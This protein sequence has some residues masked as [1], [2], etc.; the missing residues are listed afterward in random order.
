MKT[1]VVGGNG[2]IGSHLVDKLVENDWEVVILDLH[3]RRYDAIP[4]QVRFIRGDL[5]Q[6]YLVR[7]SLMGVDVVFHLAWSGIPEISIIDP[8]AAIQTNLHPSI[9]LFDACL[10]AKVGRVIFISSGGTIYGPAQAIP[11]PE[12]HPQSPINVYGINKLMTEKYLEM[13]NILYGLDYAIIR[14]SVPY[15]PRQNHLAKQG[16]IAVF[17]YR[18][19]K[20]I[21][22]AIWGDGSITRDFFYISD[23]A[24]ALIACAERKIIQERIYNIG[25]GKEI[26]LN[27]L[28]K[29]IEDT[30]GKKA[31]VEYHPARKFDA[32]RIVLDIKR[33]ERELDWAPGISLQQGLTKTWEWMSTIV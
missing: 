14:P 17:L 32:S 18:V 27:S 4:S 28:L 12:T 7:E 19:A 24:A 2:F 3:E 30:V 10:Q 22:I 16:A 5:S 8:I 25:G 20:Q 11:I 23:L 33:A 9:N 26:S 6:S 1:L 15:G 21:P 29:S 31:I 13:Y